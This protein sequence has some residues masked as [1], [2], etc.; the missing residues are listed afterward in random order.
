[1][2]LAIIFG[3]AYEKNR[4]LPRMGSA[5][6]DC[7]LAARRLTEPDAGF[8]V[9]RFAADRDLPDA[10]EQFL[11]AQKGK[12]DQLL[13]Y[14][15][16]YAVLSPARGPGLVLDGDK[17]A[18]L[19]ARI[20][21]DLLERHAA[22]SCVVVDA[23]AVLEPGQTVAAVV[24]G[25]G[26]ALTQGSDRVSALIAARPS[27]DADSAGSPFTNLLVTVLDWL[28]SG[29]EANE[30]IDLGRL[31]E[32]LCADASM[33]RAIPA[34][35]VF[36]RT[37]S[38]S[39][40]PPVDSRGP[41]ASHRPPSDRPPPSND[42]PDSER[43]SVYLTYAHRNAR[44][45]VS[46]EPKKSGSA[47]ALEQMLAG[48]PND[49]GLRDR[50]VELYSDHGYPE[51]AL[52]HCR[53]LARLAPAR[54]ETY[55]RARTLFERADVPDA[56]WN[57]TRVLASLEPVPG[58]SVP[59][60]SRD[61]GLLAVR[62]TIFDGDWRHALAPSPDED[63][64]FDKLL[65]VL[66]PASIRVGVAFVKQKK[67]QSETR[68]EWLHDLEK[69]TTTMAKTL[70]WTSRV[71]GMVPPAL[72][73]VPD[74][75]ATL[76]VA[77]TEDRA[78]LAGR[79]LGTGL[80]LSQLAFLWGRH[81]CRFRPSARAFTFF[82]TPD[83]LAEFVEAAALLSGAGD[84]DIR[85]LGADGKRLLATLGA[86]VQGA[87]LERLKSATRDFS[88]EGLTERARRAMIRN[89]L[90]GIRAG[91]VACGDVVVAAKLIDKLPSGGLTSAEE[92]KGELYAFAISDA[93][94]LLR[95]RLGV[96]SAA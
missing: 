95:Q 10:L 46:L 30:S 33:W 83:D 80:G 88:I 28:A 62:D 31:F 45:T 40:L 37:A 35:A 65:E 91:L 24:S 42:A 44:W 57:A 81:L 56:A 73:V 53:Y 17:V 23:A 2:R 27:T 7:E 11:S 60:P 78:I 93:Y 4:T 59:P 55:R 26:T 32:G 22:S 75:G 16:G 96:A 77:T 82:Q 79:G 66:A 94:G 85:I 47:N 39:V 54:A 1:M 84:A 51:K 76:E 86:D 9:H 58:D 71:L 19:S 52:E 64:A 15:A 89:E 43:R 25:M 5:E 12:I 49:L 63:P 21:R 72:Y 61:D 6:I 70:L 50:L 74:L 29:R 92:Q 69:S 8:A 68:P 3:S 90:A 87:E 13:V 36:P 48:R 34:G 38:F 67:R 18:G 20:L 41:T 14:F